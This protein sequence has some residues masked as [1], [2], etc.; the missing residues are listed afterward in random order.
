MTS[1]TWREDDK[2]HYYGLQMSIFIFECEEKCVVFKPSTSTFRWRVQIPLF[3][4]GTD[5][6]LLGYFSD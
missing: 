4:M 5:K 1:Q 6:S 2:I 3:D